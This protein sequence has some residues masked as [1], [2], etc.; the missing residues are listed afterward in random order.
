M[1]CAQLAHRE[2]LRVRG[3]D[4]INDSDLEEDEEDGENDDEEGADDDDAVQEM[5]GNEKGDMFDLHGGD[6][7]DDRDYLPDPHFWQL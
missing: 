5:A 6:E 1:L 4:R 2:K 7:V 3:F